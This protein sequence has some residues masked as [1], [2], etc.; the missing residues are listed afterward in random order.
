[1]LLLVVTTV[2][3]LFQT[4]SSKHVAR[5]ELISDA[6]DSETFTHF[7]TRVGLFVNEMLQRPSTDIVMVVCHGGVINA[8]FDFVFNIGVFRSCDIWNWNTAVTHFEYDPAVGHRAWKL[9]F[10]GRTDHLN[11]LSES[12]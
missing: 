7:R 5:N 12:H 10:Q 4:S 9:H 8:V 3:G 11:G 6:A 1:V 2:I